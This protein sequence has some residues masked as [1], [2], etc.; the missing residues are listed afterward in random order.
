VGSRHTS[1]STDPPPP[2][3][4]TRP[5]F[6][7]VVGSATKRYAGAVATALSKVTLLRWLDRLC[8]SCHDRKTRHGWALVDGHGKRP[9]VPPDDPRHPKHHPP[10]WRDTG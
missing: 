3:V 5:G 9:L 1:A 4:R 10:P 8:V 2:V 6:A 7:G